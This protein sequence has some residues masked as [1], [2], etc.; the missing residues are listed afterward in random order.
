MNQHAAQ[1]PAMPPRRGRDDDE[2]NDESD[3]VDEEEERGNREGEGKG[4]LEGILFHG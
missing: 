2:G 4:A 3:G 1:L